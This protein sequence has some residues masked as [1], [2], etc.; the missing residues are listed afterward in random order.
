MSVKI[1]TI[2][3]KNVINGNLTIL[4]IK[5]K[6]TFIGLNI[7]VLIA[8]GKLPKDKLNTNSTAASIIRT[9]LPIIV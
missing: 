3:I 5:I 8:L 4:S 9:P 1:S 7:F 6:I 2:S